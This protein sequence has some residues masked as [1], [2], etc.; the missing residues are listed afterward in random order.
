MAVLKI[1]KQDGT[2]AIVGDQSA[3]KYI[4]QNLTDTQK[5]QARTNIGAL[6]TEDIDNKLD[7][8][9][10]TGSGT[11]LYAY[12]GTTQTSIGVDSGGYRE[13]GTIAKFN[14]ETT[15]APVVEGR[16]FLTSSEP[17]KEGHVAT[18]NYVDTN[19]VGKTTAAAKL[20]GTDT[21]GND[22]TY[23]VSISPTL[24]AFTIPERDN[25]GR[26]Q[27]QAPAADLHCAN[28]KYVDDT[29]D[30]HDISA[31]EYVEANYIKRNAQYQ[32]I[33]GDI[34]LTGDLTVQG[35]T[36]TQDNETIRIADN[37][38][39]LNSNKENN[40]TT[41]SGIA[42]NKDGM[43]TYGIMYNPTTNTVDLGEGKTVGGVFEFN[44]NEGS[45][46]AVRD[47]SDNIADGAIMVF[48]KKKNR[49]VDSGFTI[50]SMQEWVRHYV[51]TYMS[52]MIET[53]TNETGET[54]VVNTDEM[55]IRLIDNDEGGQTLIIE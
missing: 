44:E 55:N 9:T 49:L 20:Y 24:Y 41:L 33:S 21:N 34:F 32:I 19:F 47:N 52:T 10:N 2:W 15:A 26:L 46:L 8:L 35:Q 13:A 4:E 31:K 17:T 36:F 6:S 40:S 38:I 50:E 18:K 16:G 30:S 23:T 5:T 54:L 53:E 14:N 25:L 42:I 48:D 3:I 51:D 45:P 27:T 7:K 39:E 37:I 43:D 29:I 11:R 12:Y 1:R 28:K 22:T